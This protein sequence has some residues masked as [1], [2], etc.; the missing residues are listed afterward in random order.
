MPL[1]NHTHTTLYSAQHTCK[2]SQL[3]LLHM[4][5]QVKAIKEKLGVTVNDVLMGVLGCAINRTL[6]KIDPEGKLGS[7]DDIKV[8]SGLYIVSNGDCYLIHT[9][10]RSFAK[11]LKL[12]GF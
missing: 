11:E 6:H 7:P 1:P 5:P 3:A 2:P 9:F 4:V 12:G 10:S 8:C